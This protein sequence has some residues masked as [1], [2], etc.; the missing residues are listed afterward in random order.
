MK[1]EDLISSQDFTKQMNKIQREIDENTIL[2]NKLSE[3]PK[4]FYEFTD[5]ILELC[6]DA[7][8]LFRE[9]NAIK[10]RQLLKLI[11]RNYV[12]QD[13]HLNYT[14]NPIF[15]NLPQIKS[16]LIKTDNSKKGLEL[17][18]TQ[19]YQEKNKNNAK[20]QRFTKNEG[21][22]SGNAVII[23]KKRENSLNLINGAGDEARTRD[24]LLGNNF[25]Y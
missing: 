17:V 9:A 3:E 8:K 11:G 10:K 12:L 21:S 18:K 23:A 19:A 5:N 22:N 16:G 4:Q 14:L 1:L 20:N 2:R 6:Q 24:I 7:P 15:K 13:K 25:I